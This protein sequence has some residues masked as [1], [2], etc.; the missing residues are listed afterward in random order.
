MSNNTAIFTITS[1]LHSEQSVE[2]ATKEYLQSL[3]EAG[4]PTVDMLGNDYDSY[5]KHTLN[6]L[7]IRTGGTEGLFRQLLPKFQKQS[8][9]PFYLLTS[10]KSNSLAASMEILAYLKQHD[11]KGE[12][13]HGDASYVAKRIRLLSR[14]S[15][16]RKRIDGCRLGVIG[17]PSDWLIASKADT[18]AIKDSLSIDLIEIA[19][20]EVIETIRNMQADQASSKARLTSLITEL[21]EIKTP[22]PAIAQALPGAIHIYKALAKIVKHYR[23]NGF[24]IRC[25]DLLT[26]VK[27]TGCLALAKL[28]AEEIVSGCEGDVPALITMMVTQALTGVTG[29]QANPA[30]INPLTGEILLA[31]CTIPLN[32]VDHFELDTHFESGIGVGIRGFMKEGPVTLFKLSGD[33]KRHFIAEGQLTAC[34][35]Q[36]NLCRTQ[37]SI[38]L[39]DKSDAAY[40]L[41]NPIGNHHIVMPGLQKELLEEI[42]K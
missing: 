26:A 33:L 16:A 12:I 9:Q 2:K 36:N 13:L 10:G 8:K 15:E 6:L 42:L 7:F 11:I 19:I 38:K 28:N 18:T 17:R 4:M 24:T 34:L 27:N 30:H 32:M 1:P 35:S 3:R 40:F 31:H 23:L 39:K 22:A 37:M 41:S 29:F 25:F 21:K 14:I 5:G 20:E